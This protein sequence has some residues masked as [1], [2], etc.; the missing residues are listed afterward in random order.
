GGGGG[1][2]NLT[3]T[4]VPLSPAQI[5]Y[6][7]LPAAPKGEEWAAITCP[8]NQP[9]G[10]V[11]LESKGGGGAPP[12]TPQEL[13][14]I[15]EGELTVPALRPQ[16]APPATGDGLVGLPE[17]FWI[18]SAEWKA[19][20]RTVSVGG[21]WATVTATPEQITF[22]PGGGLT[23]PTCAGPGLGGLAAQQAARSDPCSYSYDQ[24]S[25]LQPRGTYAAAVVVTWRVT[26]TGSGG[27]GGTLNAGL[28]VPFPLPLRVAEG[29]AL[30]TGQ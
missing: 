3:C 2:G 27:V 21:V 29:Q 18:P 15:A 9:F 5:S 22:D 26:W 20:F 1:G 6:L 13:L 14:Q 17:L 12:V 19:A 16:T 7:G 28:Q 8:G 24:S 10:G 4:L 23:G 25:A 11:T 30:V